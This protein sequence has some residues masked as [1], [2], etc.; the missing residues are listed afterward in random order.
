MIVKLVILKCLTNLHVGNGDINYNIVDNEVEKD[1]VTNY[2]TIHSSGVKGALRSFLNHSLNDDKKGYV[3]QWFGSEE[4]TQNGKIKVLSAQIMAIPLRASIGD[5]AYYLTTTKT[6]MESYRNLQNALVFEDVLQDEPIN[7][8]N[9][10]QAEGFINMS[11]TVKFCE[12]ELWIAEDED[13]RNVELPI[14]ARNHLDDGGRSKNLW[15]EEVV[16]H[17]SIFFFPV[18]VEDSDKELMDEF[19]NNVSGR[20][21]Q[22]GGKASIG[23]GLCKVTVV[24]GRNDE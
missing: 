9:E 6:M 7:Q 16:P 23:Y 12:E 3:K 5:A 24:G 13:M 18:L 14:I 19:V 11:S 10:I 21:I 17:E 1:S 22:F 4:T 8:T 15:Y 2:P 20:V